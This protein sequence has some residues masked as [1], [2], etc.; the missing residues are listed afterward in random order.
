MLEA[1]DQ[2]VANDFLCRAHE[3]VSWIQLVEQRQSIGTYP[4]HRRLRAGIG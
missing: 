2:C 4:L 3:T 1:I